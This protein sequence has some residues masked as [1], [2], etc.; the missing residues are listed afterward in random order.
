[1]EIKPI[2]P[3]ENKPWIFIERTN[4]KAEALIFWLP[5]AKSQL[6]GKHPDAGKDWELK[7]KRVAEDEM[8]RQHHWLSGYEFERSLGDSGGQGSLACCSPCSA[9]R[10]TGLSDRTT[11]NRFWNYITINGA[12]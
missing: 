12:H 5:D 6:I 11:T 1:M 10:Q 3:K 9:K 4:A 8:V 7:E 2:N